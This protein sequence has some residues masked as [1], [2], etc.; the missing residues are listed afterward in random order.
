MGCCEIKSTT[1]GMVLLRVIGM[2]STQPASHL[3]V[4]RDNIMM[5]S[6]LLRP[7]VKGRTYMGI[8]K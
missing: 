3:L 4:Q 6:L 1:A 2:R 5:R 8:I 7:A